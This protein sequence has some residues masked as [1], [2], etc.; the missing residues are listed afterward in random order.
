[1]LFMFLIFIILIAATPILIRLL[2]IYAQFS[3]SSYKEASGNSYFQ[4]AFNTG[5][6]GE[7]LTFH[8]LEKLPGYKK[9]LTNLYIPKEDGKTTEV[10]VV[11]VNAAGIFVFESK[12]YSGW[13]FGDEKN[14]TWTQTLKNGQKN[15]FYNP[16][17]QNN[18]HVTAL[19]NVIQ[20]VDSELFHSYII[21]SERCELKKVNVISPH[22]KVIKRNRLMATIKKHMDLIGNKFT[23]AEVKELFSELSK[24]EL[25]DDAKKQQHIANIKKT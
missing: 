4:T 16:I 25:A 9:I 20:S 6:Y 24:Y 2:V 11:M 3:G 21:F 10:D 19:K 22:V 7:F 12:N 23:N 14:R 13:I 8:K 5:N 18:T 1:M 17:W 15:R